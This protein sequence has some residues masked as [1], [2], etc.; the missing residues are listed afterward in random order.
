MN[1]RLLKT[2]KLKSKKAI[3]LLF[4]KGSSNTTFP[5]KVFYLEGHDASINQ[6]AFVASKRNMK[7]AIDRNR[8]K[9]Q[10]REAYRLNKHLLKTNN[11]SKFALLFLYI[12]KDKLPYSTIEGAM[13]SLLKKI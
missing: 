2:E 4:E 1:F 9:R 11:G 8:I 12:S 13:K 10:V 7:R 5:L 3:Q 6:V